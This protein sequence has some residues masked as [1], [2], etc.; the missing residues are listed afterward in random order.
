MVVKF[1]ETVEETV[2]TEVAAAEAAAVLVAAVVAAAVVAATVVV[3]MVVAWLPECPPAGAPKEFQKDIRPRRNCWRASWFPWAGALAARAARVGTRRG[4]ICILI[5]TN[6]GLKN[7][8]V[9]TGQNAKHNR[10]KR[11]GE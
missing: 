10:A 8:L 7:D 3:V 4:E 11:R 2:A 9:G 5:G 6:V 1:E